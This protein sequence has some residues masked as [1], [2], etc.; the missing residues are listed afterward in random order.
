M[1]LRLR[2]RPWAVTPLRWWIARERLCASFAKERSRSDLFTN[3]S[4]ANEFRNRYE[5]MI[6]SAFAVTTMKERL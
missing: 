1:L 3:D 5:N 4:P 6:G 2:V